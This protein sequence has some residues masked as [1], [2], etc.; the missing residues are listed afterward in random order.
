M[1]LDGE[2]CCVLETVVVLTGEGTGLLRRWDGG[3]LGGCDW[4]LSTT[5][6]LSSPVLDDG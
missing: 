1:F 2:S 4:E 5:I 3:D 6:V